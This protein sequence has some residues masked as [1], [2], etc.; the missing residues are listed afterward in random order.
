MTVCDINQAMLAVG[1]D[2]RSIAAWWPA[3]TGPRATPGLPFE[4]R[5]FD[6]YTIAF[7]LRNVTDIDKALAEAYRVLKAGRSLYCLE[8][9]R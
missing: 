5:S 2:G 8:F 6:G 1:R 3:W 9:S 4:D 7:G